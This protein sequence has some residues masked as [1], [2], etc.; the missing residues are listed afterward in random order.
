LKNALRKICNVNK[1][2]WDLKIQVVLWAYRITCK[3]MTG[4]TPFRLVYGQ[5]AVV[6]LEFL[7][8]SMHVVTITN[9]TKRGA[10]Q[11][12][13][14]QLMELEEVKILAGFHQEVHKSR[15]KSLHD[16]HI[17]NKRRREI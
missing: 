9:M 11:E 1:D 5:E 14:R 8:P 16:R 10:I 6:P 7:V 4:H 2:D 15:D 17:K 12:R 3:K 13:L